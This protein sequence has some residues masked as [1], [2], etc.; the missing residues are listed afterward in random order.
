MQETLWSV[1]GLKAPEFLKVH[2]GWICTD[3]ILCCTLIFVLKH[4][5]FVKL[6]LFKFQLLVKTKNTG[7]TSLSGPEEQLQTV[8]T[9]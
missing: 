2:T 7:Q 3:K 5:V 6:T 8:C 9:V 4:A 1:K